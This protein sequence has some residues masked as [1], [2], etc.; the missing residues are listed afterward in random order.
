MTEEPVLIEHFPDAPTYRALRVAGGMSPKTE[1]AAARG[2]PNTLYGVSL[3]HDGQVV[4]MGRIVGD[5]G[6]FFVVVDIVVTPQWQGR[7][8]GKRIM[9]ALDAWLRANTPESAYVQL[10]A[11]G[12]AKY[13]YEKFGFVETAPATV[14]MAYTVKRRVAD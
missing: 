2:L 14:N 3:V 12:D 10:A 4:G 7:G 5:G 8:L 6:C 13:L 11:D 9:A 1:E